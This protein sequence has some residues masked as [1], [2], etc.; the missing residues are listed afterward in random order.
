MR[1][2]TFEAIVALPFSALNAEEPPVA[3]KRVDI[4]LSADSLEQLV[5]AGPQAS[6][7]V[8]WGKAHKGL[9]CG[10]SRQYKVFKR[11]HSGK[12]FTYGSF[13]LQLRF[14]PK[15]RDPQVDLLCRYLVH[16]RVILTFV[17]TSRQ[18][19]V[20]I[21]PYGPLARKTRGPAQRELVPWQ[22]SADELYPLEFK[23]LLGEWEKSEWRKLP[24]GQYEVTAEYQNKEDGSIINRYRKARGEKPLVWKSK[25]WNGTIKSN[26]ITVTI[27]D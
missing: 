11:V 20:R 15:N 26:T 7:T 19:E 12:E 21:L 22:L 25:F 23:V 18:E 5:E 2:W 16:D 24:P 8:A 27:P 1:Y 3:A 4:S 14:D 10:L 17:S 6:A 9:Q 13:G